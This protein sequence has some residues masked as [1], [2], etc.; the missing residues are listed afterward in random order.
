MTTAVRNTVFGNVADLQTDQDMELQG[1]ALDLGEG[2]QIFV[3]RAGGANK[4]YGMRLSAAMK[5]Y[6]FQIDQGTVSDDISK[7]V[8]YGVAAET[9]VCGWKGFTNPS[10]EEIPFSI[11]A[12][13]DLFYALPDIYGYVMQTATTASLY[14]KEQLKEDMA[15]VQ[16]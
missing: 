13:V 12:C 9:L 3:R 6:K 2:R 16:K 10:N 5:P 14:R 15:V 8:L 1:V 7:Q 4:R 11:E